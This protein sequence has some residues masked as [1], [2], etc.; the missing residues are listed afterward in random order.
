[1]RKYVCELCWTSEK[2]TLLT[3]LILLQLGKIL[4]TDE[5]SLK[6]NFFRKKMKRNQLINR[7]I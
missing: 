3:V 1:M 7:Q 4:S 5:T 2:N 6:G